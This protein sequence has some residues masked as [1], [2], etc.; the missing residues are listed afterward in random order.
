MVV[1]SLGKEYFV[2]KDFTI[3]ADGN[4]KWAGR[5]VPG[6]DPDTKKGRILSVR[7]LYNAHYYIS[8]IINEIRIGNT[9][10]DGVKTE[11][12]MPYHCAIVREYIFRN[13]QNGDETKPIDKFLAEDKS[14]ATEK[15]S[16]A[17]IPTNI[18]VQSND[19]E[20]G[21]IEDD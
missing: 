11:Q 14:R 15:P 17:L 1:D 12:R 19:N 6:I 20:V 2:G 9:S 18:L 7:Y 21:V 16:D 10:V 5:N 3:S 8:S 13:R 4:L